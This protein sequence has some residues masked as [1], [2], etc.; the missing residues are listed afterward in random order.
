VAYEAEVDPYCY[1]GTDLLQNVPRIRD[2]EALAAFETAMVHERNLQP[3]P[4]GKL[5][6]SH[7]KAIH[8][9]LFQDVYRWAGSYRT[10][11]ISKGGSMF[12]YPEH[13]DAQMKT[14]FR[15][16]AE[17]GYLADVSADEFSTSAARFLSA[18]NAIH[19]FREGNGR[20]Q[21]AF[22]GV[23]AARAAHRLDFSRL[24]PESFLLAMIASFQG[25]EQS[26]AAEIRGLI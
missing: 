21:N 2:A 14:V 22:L 6:V 11:R 5:T 24:N 15:D 13:I 3:L 17:N 25:D 8:K 9:H 12:C 26:L 1:R 19:P 7:Y 18:L 20:T 23:L 10:V 16:L 4:R